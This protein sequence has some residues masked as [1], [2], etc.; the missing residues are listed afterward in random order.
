MQ[1]NSEAYLESQ[2]RRL[3]HDAL[4]YNFY[5]Y[6]SANRYRWWSRGINAFLLLLSIG[7][8]SGLFSAWQAQSVL[9]LAIAVASS[10][11]LFTVIASLTVVEIIFQFSRNTG[12]TE[13]VSRQCEDIAFETR[14]LLRQIVQGTNTE[15][16]ASTA[17]MLQSL[18]NSVTRVGLPH[19]EEL[20]KK[21][22]CDASKLLDD[23]FPRTRD[24]RTSTAAAGNS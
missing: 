2:V 16:S 20:D 11:L 19:Y 1:R 7:A 12:V 8:A 14:K 3:L 23:E 6:A 22:R 13:V 21:S 10:V 24:K 9:E 15:Q 18:L 5:Y 4:R 17:D